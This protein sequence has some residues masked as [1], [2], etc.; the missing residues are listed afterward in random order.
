MFIFL[1]IV[2]AHFNDQVSL[3]IQLYQKYIASSSFDNK[4]LLARIDCYLICACARARMCVV[5][6]V[7]V[8]IINNIEH[9]I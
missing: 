2:E 9:F 8:N 6:C 7:F 3:A 1:F 4:K 5:C